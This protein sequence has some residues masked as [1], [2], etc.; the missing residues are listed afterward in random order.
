MAANAK[1]CC[2]IFGAGEAGK[3]AM[4]YLQREYHVLGFADNNQDLRGT[5]HS[6][7][8][9]ELPSYWE[10][11]K[12]DKIFIASEYFEVIRKQL[13]DTHGFSPSTIEILCANK[14]KK[15]KL[16]NQQTKQIA[17]YLLKHISTVLLDNNIAHYIDGG[18]LLGIIRDNA[19][20]PWDDDIDF[21][22]SSLDIE[23]VKE[24]ILQFLPKL[25]GLTSCEWTLDV[26]PT[27]K[28]Y[29]S[30]PIPSTRGLKLRPVVLDNTLPMVD[31]F[32]KYIETNEMYY[33]LASRGFT[34]PSSHFMTTEL[35][36]FRG[37]Q[38]RVPSNVETY[39][40][41]HYG[42]WQ[43]PM[44]NWHLGMLKNTDVFGG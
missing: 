25:K 32:V 27:V 2:I 22:I 4:Q 35:K 8:L 31:F 29:K 20:I 36:A 23:T 15:T 6:D 16:G 33:T 38:I 43:I 42:E 18:T 17:H 41:L 24:L 28:Q 11:L 39:L 14:I 21:A 3:A 12:F 19:L 10:N 7:L 13:V 1:P 44:Q 30:I 9:I 26:L 5:Y 40:T 34:M 37:H